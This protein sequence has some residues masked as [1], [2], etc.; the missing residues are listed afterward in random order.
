[1]S[2]QELSDLLKPVLGANNSWTPMAND[3]L[4]M[5]AIREGD[6][7]TARDIYGKLLTVKDLPESFKSKI[8]EMLSSLNTADSSAE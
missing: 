5:A 6:L 7:Q 3:L 2:K 1:M 8:Q 4:A